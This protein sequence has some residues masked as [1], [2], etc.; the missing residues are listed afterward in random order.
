MYVFLYKLSWSEDG[1]SKDV[2]GAVVATSYAEAMEH[3]ENYYAVV[4]VDYLF[5]ITDG[6]VLELPNFDV[7]AFA[8][9]D[10]Y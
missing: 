8:E 5:C 6:N 10:L 3:L 1:Q 9:S 2:Q 7:K 4:Q